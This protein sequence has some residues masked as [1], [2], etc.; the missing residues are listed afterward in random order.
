[1][2]PAT[3]AVVA[4]GLVIVAFLTATLEAKDLPTAANARTSALPNNPEWLSPGRP[5]SSN[6][7]SADLLLLAQASQARPER[8]PSL[9]WPPARG[10]GDFSSETYAPP[11]PMIGFLVGPLAAMTG[12]GP[13]ATP[14]PA[15]MACEEDI[16]RHI[17]L[18]AYLKSKLR[19]QG[20][21]KDAWSKLEQ[22]ADS[23][24]DKLHEACASL[25]VEQSRPP[26][27][28][29]LIAFA[30]KL[31][32]A[33]VELLHAISGPLQAFYDSLSAKQRELLDTP[34][35]ML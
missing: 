33:R 20:T 23:T 22:A 21:Q 5:T 34:P 12:H 8:L 14:L 19:L 11:P 6:E 27:I 28:T 10:F 35:P 9:L 32:S 7:Y 13:H 31:T 1:M 25:P 18:A 15:P 16:D 3:K 17:A 4:A 2:Q 24:I 30:E 29:A 26:Q